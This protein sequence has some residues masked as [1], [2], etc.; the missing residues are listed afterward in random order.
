MYAYDHTDMFFFFL[1]TYAIFLCQEKVQ[2]SINIKFSS[3]PPV[4][5]EGAKIFPQVHPDIYEN[6]RG[7]RMPK[8]ICS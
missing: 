8:E 2:D 1:L 3:L 6:S 7:A 5:P 4:N